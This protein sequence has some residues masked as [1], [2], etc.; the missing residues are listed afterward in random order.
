MDGEVVVYDLDHDKAH[1][2]NAMAAFVWREA[3]GSRSVEELARG[4]SAELGSPVDESVI[5]LALR[6]LREAKLL[7]EGE[8][9]PEI[10]TVTRRQVMQRLGTGAAAAGALIP[11]ISSLLA[12]TAAEAIYSCLEPGGACTDGPQCC[13]GVCADGVCV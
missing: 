1:C 12:P 5:W 2:L 3:D 13:S 9:L 10:P 11:V 8:S 7:L 6:R 4:A